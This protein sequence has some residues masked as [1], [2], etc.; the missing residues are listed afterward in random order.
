MS[1]FRLVEVTSLIE[2]ERDKDGNVNAWDY[3]V[4]R[5]TIDEE[6]QTTETVLL[7]GQAD[8]FESAERN[9]AVKLANLDR[10]TF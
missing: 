6:G 2:A 7:A 4:V 10:P 1:E 9:V 3:S 5:F 8:D